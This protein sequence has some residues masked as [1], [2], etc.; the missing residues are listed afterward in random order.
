MLLLFCCGVSEPVPITKLDAVA[1]DYYPFSYLDGG[2]PAG[3]LIDLIESIS[4]SADMPISRNEIRILPWDQAYTTAKQ[5]PNT[6]LLGVYRTPSREKSFKWIGPIMTDANVFFIRP[7]ANLP[8]K[9]IRDVQNLTVGV[10]AG[11]AHSELLNMYGFSQSN[12]VTSS[13]KSELVKMVLNGT[14]DTFYYG[15]GAGRS[16]AHAITGGADAL[17][18]G[19][20]FGIIDIYFAVSISTS[21]SV[22]DALQN[23]CNNNSDISRKL[24]Y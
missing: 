17:E 13:D 16:L 7:G 9:N 1:E 15:E 18:V 21:D 3:T 14:I 20:K 24:V 6:V 22:V 8:M 12:I 23:A 10:V 19:M 4:Y 2:K 11:D 5:I